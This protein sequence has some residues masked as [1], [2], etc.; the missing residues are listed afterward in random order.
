MP[1]NIHTRFFVILWLIIEGIKREITATQDLWKR[2]KR[3]RTKLQ[4]NRNLIII[5]EMGILSSIISFLQS[6]LLT[7]FHVVYDPI[8]GNESSGE[9]A[10]GFSRIDPLCVTLIKTPEFQ[11]LKDIRQLDHLYLMFKNAHHTRFA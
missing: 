1:G 6:I 5:F 10:E 3:V 4:I 11:R 8:H 9:L 7:V 2:S